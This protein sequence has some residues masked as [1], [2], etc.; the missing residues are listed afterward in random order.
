VADAEDL[1]FADGSFDVI[2]VSERQRDEFAA[3]VHNKIHGIEQPPIFN[4]LKAKNL[5]IYWEGKL[6]HVDDEIIQL[7]ESKEV[8]IKIQ[9]GLLRFSVPP[10]RQ[11]N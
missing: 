6:L 2:L 11:V 3:Y 7:D 9:E 8:K 1:P 4:I 10:V 5:E